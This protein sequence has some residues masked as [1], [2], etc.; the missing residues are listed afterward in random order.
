[1][2]AR[3]AT[4]TQILSRRGLHSGADVVRGVRGDVMVVTVVVVVV[5]VVVVRCNGEGRD[6]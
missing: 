2:K 3:R 5:T 4:L 6:M 1:M